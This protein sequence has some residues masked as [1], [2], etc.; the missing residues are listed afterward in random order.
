MGKISPL[1]VAKGFKDVL[2][3]HDDFKKMKAMGGGMSGSFY[4]AESLKSIQHLVDS[5]RKDEHGKWN[6]LAIWERVGE[7]SENANR[8]ALFR[9]L[10]VEGKSEFEA[11]F[12]AR[13]L[14]DFAAHGKNGLLRSLISIV[15]FL[16]ARLQGLH[17]IGREGAGPNRAKVIMRGAAVA[18]MSLALHPLNKA[19]Q[20]PDDPWYDMIPNYDRWAYWHFGPHI[21]IPK[22]FEIGAIFGELP[23]QMAD[24]FYRAAVKEEPDSFND[25]WKFTAST[26][27][28]TFAMN[29]CL[30]AAM[31]K[32]AARARVPIRGA[33]R[34]GAITSNIGTIPV[35]P[36]TGTS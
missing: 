36:P 24:A 26:V 20:P 32:R 14:M 7:A 13:D 9:K 6:P 25:L 3:G 17:K 1:D 30:T 28:D 4:S 18:A 34:C 31:M 23:V 27:M 22:P 8:L 35:S 15:P 21:A 29:S 12:Q 11:G 16:N 10:Q 5:T 33:M 19:A 2:K